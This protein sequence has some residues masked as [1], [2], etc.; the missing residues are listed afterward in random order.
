MITIPRF[1]VACLALGIAVAAVQANQAQAVFHSESVR[2]HP[3]IL[4]QGDLEYGLEATT[5]VDGTINDEIWVSGEG[6]YLHGT[7]L[8]LTHPTL[9]GPMWLECSIEV[10]DPPDGNRNGISDFFEVERAVTELPSVGEF[11]FDDG[12]DVYQGLVDMTWNRAAGET[13]GTCGLRLRILDYGVDLTF[14][15]SF[16]VY[17]YR[18]TFDYSV[19]GAQ[20]PGRLSVTRQGAAGSLDGPLLFERLDYNEL[21]F[22][23]FALTDELGRAI[24]FYSSADLEITLLRGAMLSNYYTIVYTEDGWP[25]TP[26]NPEYEIWN[27]HL[28]DANDSDQDRIPDL[29]D[30]PPPPRLSIGYSDKQ[31]RIEI[32]A[33]P[34]QQVT[35]EATTAVAPSSWEAVESVTLTSATHT[36][37]IDTPSSPRFWRARIE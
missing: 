26:T 35:L 4:S 20:V 33:Q 13:T 2:L 7:V 18:G 32:R 28:L 3:A 1:T 11:V 21:A 31:L 19:E 29:S 34:G 16:E 12:T 14:V 6:P 36:F 17:D 15:H 30:D 5:A 27:L 23:A 9:P 25:G 22:P 10:P 37:E 8:V 24:Q